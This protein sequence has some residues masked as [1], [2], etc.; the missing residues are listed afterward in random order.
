MEQ[1]T[2]QPPFY[3]QRWFQGAVAL[4]GLLTAVWALVGAPKPWSVAQDLRA[5][6]VPLSN[7]EIVLDTSAAMTKPFGK[8][9]KLDAAKDA[10][11][12]F[13]ASAASTGLALR[14]TGGG[15]YDDGEVVVG[16]GAGHGDDVR[17][18]VATARPGG[19]SNLISTVNGAIGEFTD[20]RFRDSSS[21]RRIVV[22]MGGE[23]R[24]VEAEGEEIRDALAGMGVKTT[25]RMYALGLSKGEAKQMSHFIAEVEPSARVDLLPIASEEE[26]HVAIDQE[27]EELAAG[28]VPELKTAAAPDFEAGEEEGAAGPESEG[29][30]P[31]ESEEGETTPET[32]EPPGEESG[33][34]AAGEETK[35]PVEEEPPVEPA[36]FPGS[37][38]GSLS[39][40]ALYAASRTGSVFS[41][42]RNADSANFGRPS[43]VMF[44]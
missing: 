6:K 20:E 36:P 19:A 5:T 37:E 12:E 41:W 13:S 26:L 30:E 21:M 3:E 18:A 10:I 31:P 9:T 33:E 44:G 14:Q 27:A 38:I 35:G 7:T 1:P 32:E 34:E 8:G 16:F 43:I 40:S 22:F 23:D 17:D 28:E 25:F 2:Q 11:A 39:P 24:C 4:V 42:L 29:V 15:C